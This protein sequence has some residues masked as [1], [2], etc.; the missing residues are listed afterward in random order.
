MGQLGVIWGQAGSNGGQPGSSG[1]NRDRLEVKW[2]L[3]GN[4][5]WLG[6]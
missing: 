6:E 4:V 3:V 2:F 5:G 1:V